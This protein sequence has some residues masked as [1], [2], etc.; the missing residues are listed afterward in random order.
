[1]INNLPIE[2]RE[3]VFGPRPNKKNYFSLV[4]FNM[5]HN[6]IINCK[7][8]LLVVFVAAVAQR[9]VRKSIRD[10]GSI[11]NIFLLTNNNSSLRWTST[12][13]LCADTDSLIICVA[14]LDNS[15]MWW[16]RKCK[17]HSWSMDVVIV[18]TT[19]TSY[20]HPPRQPE[21]RNSLLFLQSVWKLAIC[22]FSWRSFSLHVM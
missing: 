12:V 7:D 14:V 8:N 6:M 11:I 18:E 20:P 17:E 15:F 21:M 13:Q 1:M 5:R 16:G 4:R 10:L 22:I 19:C 2:V 3:N 9:R